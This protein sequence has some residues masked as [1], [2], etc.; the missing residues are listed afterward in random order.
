MRVALNKHMFYVGG[1]LILTL[2]IVFTIQSK[3]G[4]SPF[5]ALL[6]GLH[7]TVGLTVGSWEIV[8]GIVM[9]GFNALAQ[10]QKPEYL[11]LLTAFITGLGIDLWLILLRDVVQPSTIL[12][13]SL[14]FSLGLIAVCLGIATYLKAN[15]APIPIDRMMLV[16][17]QL[18]G[19]SLTISRTLINIV[20]VIL[21]YL[22]N[23]PIGV[24]T[25]LTL[26]LSGIIINFFMEYLE[27]LESKNKPRL[28]EQQ[29]RGDSTQ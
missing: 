17:R 3:L 16:I 26:L 23:G 1:I 18:T 10:K 6:V 21:A 27:R 12:I 22:F 15:F 4:T 28:I 8:L 9:I 29:D 2:G 13:Q 14:I 20:L 5:D 25:L 19:W 7:R 11:A 24:G